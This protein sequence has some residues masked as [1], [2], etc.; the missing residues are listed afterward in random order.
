MTPLTSYI[1]YYGPE[2][3]GEKLSFFEVVENELATEV[4]IMEIT[5]GGAMTVG[6]AAVNSAGPSEVAYYQH[7][8][9]KSIF[10]SDMYIHVCILESVQ[11]VGSYQ[12]MN[13]NLCRQLRV[14]HCRCPVHLCACA[15]LLVL[16]VLLTVYH[17]AL[18][19]SRK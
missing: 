15:Y 16:W 5:A 11:W 13:F 18:L 8:V 12:D 7:R 4:T 9:G 19:E 17:M 3:I 10:T 6:V 14:K 1:V 2:G